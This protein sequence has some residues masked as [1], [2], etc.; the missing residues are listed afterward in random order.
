MSAPG[1]SLLLMEILNLAALF[2]LFHTNRIM[3]HRV[4]NSWYADIKPGGSVGVFHRGIIPA[5]GSPVFGMEILNTVVPLV[6]SHKSR[7]MSAQGSPVL[8]I[9]IKPGDPLGVFHESWR[10][11][12]PDFSVREMETFNQTRPLCFSII[13]DFPS[14]LLISHSSHIHLS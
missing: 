4:P 8:V 9:E 5:E 12:S 1:F 3:R 13:I 10:M 11:L 2:V 14:P 7:I 6:L